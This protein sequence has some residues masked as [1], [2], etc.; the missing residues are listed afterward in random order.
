M[1]HHAPE[2]LLAS[3]SDYLESG[4]RGWPRRVYK[5]QPGDAGGKTTHVT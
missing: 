2:W 4:G 5:T 1:L 3:R